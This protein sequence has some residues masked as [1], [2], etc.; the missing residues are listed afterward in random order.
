[1]LSEQHLQSLKATQ[2]LNK[3]LKFTL[4]NIRY[5]PSKYRYH[6]CE[7]SNNQ[8]FSLHLTNIG[9]YLKVYTYFTSYGTKKTSFAF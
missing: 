4:Q 8:I 3:K 9:L 1:M 5:F 6:F 7:T 2:L